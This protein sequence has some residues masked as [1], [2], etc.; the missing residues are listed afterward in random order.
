[1]KSISF[2]INQANLTGESN[3]TTKFCE[4][5]PEANDIITKKNMLF[6]GT[7]VEIGHAIGIVVETGMRTEL[8]D[9]QAQVEEAKLDIA[10]ETTPLKKK[11][12]DFSDFLAK[13]ILGICVIIWA[14]NFFNFFDPIHGSWVKGCLYYFK[15]AV[16]LA[17]AAIPE[18]LPAVITTC[19]ALGTRRMTK[20]HAIV[21]KLPS[22]ET[23]GCT[24]VICSDKTGTLTMNTMAC[25]EF[26]IFNDNCN[27][28]ESSTVEN[29]GYH[30]GG[31]ISNKA[32]SQQF[33]DWKNLNQVVNCMLLNNLSDWNIVNKEVKLSGSSTE[34]AL[35][36]L[37]EKLGRYNPK[38]KVGEGNHAYLNKITEAEGW[39]NKAF[40]EFS[41]KRKTMSALWKDNKSENNCLFIKG[42]PERLIESA[43]NFMAKDGSLV[44][45][46][47]QDK[48]N[49]EK[50]VH[51]I[52]SRGLRVLALSVKL[53]AGELRDYK[54]LE[55][56]NHPAHERLSEPKSY[57]DFESGSTLLGFVG[58][59][60]PIR[61]EVKGSI[62]KCNTAGILVF[63]VTG[64][65]VETAVSIAKEIGLVPERIRQ[66][67]LKDYVV[68]GQDFREKNENDQKV[69]L[70]KAFRDHHGLIFAR[71]APRDKRQLV[72][73]LK[74][75]GNI[76][77]MT[78]D[79]VNDAPALKQADIG[80]AMG[81][82]GTDV[83]KEASEMILADDNFA[84]IVD[85][86]E[87][88]RAIYD[89]MKAFI[90][91]M[92]SSNIG[93]VIS[94]FLSAVMGIP[95][96]FN[97]IQ[98]LWVNLVTDGLPATALSFNPP[99]CEIMIK[100]P[101]KKDEDIIGGWTLV[102]F[103]VIGLYIGLA[104][105]GIFVYW[106][107]A[108]DWSGYDHPLVSYSE[109]K[110]WSEC[111]SWDGFKVANF[112][113]YDFSKKPC[114]YFMN[115]KGKASTLSL[116][117]LVVIEMLNAL[118]AISE[119]QSILTSGFFANPW[120]LLAIGSSVALHCVILY[121]PFFNDLF[122]T[123]PLNY[124]DWYLV[125]ICSTP[126]ILIDEV[127][128]FFSRKAVNRAITEQLDEQEK[129][130]R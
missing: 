122:S 114:D 22:V 124:Q 8:G 113:H 118:N 7:L 6:S 90:R 10:E 88:G 19:L 107:V 56:K 29:T 83:A 86:I 42:A 71:T 130:L 123:Q 117:V 51:E 93:E 15:V 72:K 18:G 3:A 85:A 11:L 62:Q 92:I 87:E 76:S 63:M 126:V 44:S 27:S 80:I 43:D 12:D 96:G 129:K 2:K 48:Q 9:I 52:A 28:L 77:A 21:K 35:K 34:V 66:E 1:M 94:I 84:T 119:N 99:D 60:D 32:F 116:T 58:M 41:S 47:N 39:D 64:D 100:P 110:D 74:E 26:H 45:L 98:L 46:S 20:K 5:I 125:L 25:S 128:K 57:V 109:L 97:S 70:K 40:L 23:L 108:Y 105:V 121:I 127:L 16:A 106:Y 101:R 104:T 13:A 78:G 112:L 65:I 102:R 73:L 30:L 54:G 24:T 115:G 55:D 53:D 111:P 95:D 89:N 59:K 68:T 14:V 103:L 49:L 31:T 75:L 36:V 67:D 69:F 4:A 79:G 33:G 61:P 82:T 38:H 81:I 37:G 120:L 17:V 91:Y 50:K